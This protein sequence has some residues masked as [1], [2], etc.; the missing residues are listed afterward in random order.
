[1]C[2]LVVWASPVNLATRPELVGIAQRRG[3]VIDILEDGQDAGREVESS[4]M[5]RILEVGGLPPE[6]FVL[7]LSVDP[8]EYIPDLQPKTRRLRVY[9][10][11]LDA[12]E[13]EVGV[14]P[15]LQSHGSISTTRQMI[16]AHTYEVEREDNPLVI[17]EEGI[18]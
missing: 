12:I 18:G 2:R 6:D 16:D 8:Y 1:M 4:P 13:N 9:A 3:H 10:L 5:F 15:M 14:S 11:D 17:G 7:L